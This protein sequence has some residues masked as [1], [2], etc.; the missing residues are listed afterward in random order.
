MLVVCGITAFFA[1]ARQAETIDL[2]AV[3]RTSEAMRKRGPDASG[4][5]LSSDSRLAM[6]HRRLAIIDPVESSGQPMHSAD[7]RFTI[8]FNGEIYNHAELRESLTLQGH[9]FHT[10]S[11]TEVLLHLYRAEGEGM[12]PRLRG[13]FAFCIWDASRRQLFLARDPYGVKPLYYSVERGT[14]RVASQVK[15]LQAGGGSD[16]IDPA[17]VAGFLLRGSVPEPF[18]LFEGIRSLPA[19]SSMSVTENG[20]GEVRSYFSIAAILREAVDAERSPEEAE[21]EAREALAESVRYHLVSDVPIGAFLS[22]GK[23]STS[24]VALADESGIHRLKLITLAFEEYSGLHADEAP[25]ASDFARD[26]GLQHTVSVLTRDEFRN[27]LPRMLEAMDQPTIDGFNSYFVSRAAA[28]IG[29]KVMLSG[30]GGDELLGGYS[31]FRNI[32]ALIRNTRPFANIPLLP[33]L[34]R[35]AYQGLMP[36]GPRFSPKTASTVE[37]GGTFAKAY[38]L[39]RG[40]FLPWELPR[41]IGRELAHEGLERLQMVDRIADALRPDPGTAWARVAALE[42]SFFLRDQL[43]RD[44]DWA[45]MAHSLEVRVPLVDPFLLRKLARHVVHGRG[46]QKRLLTAA[47]TRPLPSYIVNRRKS[48]F[49]LPLS[50]WLWESG[51]A[52]FGMRDWALTLLRAF[53]PNLPPVRDGVASAERVLV[54]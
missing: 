5:W 38:L 6:A 28:G 51:P 44:I 3:V 36:V 16:A 52:Q 30:T 47:P 19:G 11:D 1:F 43:L 34:L 18:T 27:E 50:K 12:L 46:N 40:L 25:A 4:L 45:S 14:V 21:R 23:D 53:A 33:R 15:A 2:E 24:V 49:T 10:R 41:V 31:T 22:A 8:V 7:R 32:P 37:Y 39:K 26:R 17:G 48:G 13:M 42:S 35:G 54:K 20:P 29:C 9:E